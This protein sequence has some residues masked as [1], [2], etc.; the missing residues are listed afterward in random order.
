[1]KIMSEQ[2]GIFQIKPYHAKLNDKVW[3]IFE[4]LKQK[5]DQSDRVRVDP[6]LAEYDDDLRFQQLRRDAMKSLHILPEVQK[7]EE[8]YQLSGDKGL[9]NDYYSPDG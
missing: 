4:K 6:R 3:K 5:A 8:G 1:M 7:T 2:Y 9:D